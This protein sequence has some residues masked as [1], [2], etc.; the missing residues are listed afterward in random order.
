ML[1]DA[2][3][4]IADSGSTGATGEDAPW[5][6][7]RGTLTFDNTMWAELHRGTDTSWDDDEW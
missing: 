6:S 7:V 3:S 5:A 2:S 4:V 1:I